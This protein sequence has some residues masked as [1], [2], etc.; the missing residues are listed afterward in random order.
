[1]SDTQGAMTVE[2][3][4]EE[5]T[6]K[7]SFEWYN[8]KLKDSTVGRKL[9]VASADEQRAFVLTA[10]KCFAYG[11]VQSSDKS[12]PVGLLHNHS[13]F[14]QV[15]MLTLLNRRLPL[16]HDDVVM[17]LEWSI[18]ETGNYWRGVPQIIR[19]VENYLRDDSLTPLLKDKINQLA[20]E[21][22]TGYS[23]AETRKYLIKLKELTGQLKMQIPLVAGEAWSDKAIEDVNTADEGKR[24]AWLELLNLCATATGSTPSAKWKKQVAPLLDAIGF[25]EFKQSM[26]RW[27]ALADKPRTQTIETWAQYQPNPNLVMNDR[28]ADVLRGLVWLCAEREDKETA[29]ALT[30]LTGSAY[31]KVAGIGARCVRVGNACVWALGEMPGMEG[32]GQLALL[33]VR[34][35]FGTAQKMIDAGLAKAANRTGLAVSDIEELGVPDYGLDAGGKRVEEFGDYTAEIIASSANK[36]EVNWIRTSEAKRLASVPRAVKESYGERLKELMSRVKDIKQMLPA[37]RDRIENLYLENKRWTFEAWRER[38]LNHPLI[39]VIARRLI[40][41]FTNDEQTAAGLW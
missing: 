35:K 24:K 36:L 26:V 17:L 5:V 28:N 39:G 18:R 37:Q 20:R 11:L 40:W 16:T 27:F 32:I 2:S 33:R 38:Y 6:V 29:R 8:F 34:V 12:H 10:L 25:D 21:L 13:F 7:D 31:R 19:A 22:D 4:I 23:T 15:A 3:F 9:L 41:R 14:L 1:M 30:G